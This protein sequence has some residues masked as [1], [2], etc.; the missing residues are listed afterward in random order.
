MGFVVPSTLHP[1][2][3]AA[4]EALAGVTAVLAAPSVIFDVH[5]ASGAGTVPAEALAG[6][7]DVLAGVAVFE[8]GGAFQEAV[9]AGIAPEALVCH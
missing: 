5:P 2:D 4:P 7:T 9:G 6:A 1:A 8:A 3:A